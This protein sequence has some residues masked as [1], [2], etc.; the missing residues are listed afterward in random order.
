VVRAQPTPEPTPF[1]TAPSPPVPTQLP[2]ETQPTAPTAPVPQDALGWTDQLTAW[3]TL[4]TAGVAAIALIFAARAA[5]AAIRT[6]AQQAQQLRQLEIEA[7]ERREQT[8]REQASLVCV[9]I[10]DDL[11]VWLTNASTQPIYDVT[12]AYIHRS[13]GLIE[14]W[15]KSV[16]APNT[17]SMWLDDLTATLSRRLADAVARSKN[18]NYTEY[19]LSHVTAVGD[20]IRDGIAQAKPSWVEN[21][22]EIQFRDVGGRRWRRSAAGALL[23]LELDPPSANDAQ[24]GGCATGIRS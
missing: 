15:S 11:G 2:A 12:V 1:P 14:S 4:G 3:A 16:V 13:N 10:A 21:G 18:L 6:N 8:V 7:T 9:W 22:V 24:G 20:Q 23:P 17:I 5:R 19:D